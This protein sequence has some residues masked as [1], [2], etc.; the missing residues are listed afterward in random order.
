MGCRR[1]ASR[2][3]AD[4]PLRRG[5]KDVRSEVAVL[6]RP[7]LRALFKTNS[8]ALLAAD[9]FANREEEWAAV[10]RSLARSVQARADRGFDVEDVQTPRRN[11]L[12]FYGV[13]GIGKSTLS[14]QIASPSSNP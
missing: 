9:V 13:G 12:V 8:R 7:D 6:S 10:S 1:Y 5:A 4:L 2:Q 3:G 14:K 11:V